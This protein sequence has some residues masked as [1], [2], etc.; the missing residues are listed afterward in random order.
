MVYSGCMIS[1][2]RLERL[3]NAC[4]KLKPF[5]VFKNNVDG[6]TLGDDYRIPDD[7]Y[8]CESIVDEVAH[9]LVRDRIIWWLADR[10]ADP[11]V[12]TTTHEYII[13]CLVDGESVAADPTKACVLAA[14]RELKLPEWKEPGMK[15]LEEL[16]KTLRSDIPDGASPDFCRACLAA[17]GVIREAS[18]ARSLRTSPALI[19]PLALNQ[20]DES[21]VETDRL[22]GACP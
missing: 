7:P 5:G 16:E 11:M 18:I 3:W 15:T 4:P 21:V 8:C 2:A 10:K 12:T 20:Y 17:A 19:H 6:W 9:A 1:P 22:L 13:D 14:E